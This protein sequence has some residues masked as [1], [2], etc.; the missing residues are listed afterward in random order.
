MPRL[1]EVALD[2]QHYHCTPDKFGFDT[3]DPRLIRNLNFAINVYEAAIN[4]KSYKK[5]AEWAKKNPAQAELLK[6]VRR[7]ESAQPD[8]LEVTVALPVRN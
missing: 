7:E 1:L 3:Q 6:L 5:T 4:R 2:C 8:P